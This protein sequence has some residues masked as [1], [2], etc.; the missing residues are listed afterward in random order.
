MAA[1]IIDGESIQKLAEHCQKC[2][3]ELLTMPAGDASMAGGGLQAEHGR[4][5]LWAS[6]VSVFGPSHA[7]LDYRLQD[8][9][10][11][12]DLFMA[13]LNILSTRLEQRE[14]LQ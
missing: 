3:T 12:R 10:E 14:S 1:Q 5:N 4:F 13:Q 11:A 9:P 7:C 8:V 6:S 2:F